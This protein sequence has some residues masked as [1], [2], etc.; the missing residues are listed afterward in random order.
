LAPVIIPPAPSTAAPG[1][2]PLLGAAAAFQASRRLR[3]RLS[4]SLPAA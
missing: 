1:P 4:G 2:L 3:R